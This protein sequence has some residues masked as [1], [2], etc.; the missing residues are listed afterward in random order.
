MNGWEPRE[1]TDHVY[2]GGRL[3]RTVTRREPEFSHADKVALLAL[4]AYEADLGPH[5]LPLSETTDPANQ[6]AYVA[7]NPVMDWAARAISDAQRKYYKQFPDESG[8]GHL[9]GVK[10]VQSRP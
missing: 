10:R 1:V 2:Q 4:D 3:V 7:E 9:W 8:D 6:R 5:G